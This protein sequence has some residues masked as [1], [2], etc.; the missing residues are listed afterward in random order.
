MAL[1]VRQ[2]QTELAEST[3]DHAPGA[4]TPKIGQRVMKLTLKISR[5]EMRSAAGVCAPPRTAHRYALRQGL[6]V[7]SAPPPRQRPTVAR[8]SLRCTPASATTTLSRSTPSPRSY[9]SNCP[10]G[11]AM[12]PSCC[13]ACACRGPPSPPEMDRALESSYNARRVAGPYRHS[14][15]GRRRGRWVQL[16]WD[17]LFHP[18]TRM[19]SRATWAD[20]M[21]AL[22]Q[23]PAR[24]ANRR[25]SRH[26][27]RAQFGHRRPPCRR[28]LPAPRPSHA[29]PFQ[30]PARALGRTRTSFHRQDLA[31][32]SGWDAAPHLRF[33][34][35]AGC[36]SPR[37]GLQ[38]RQRRA[39]RL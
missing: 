19:P 20:R 39:R 9:S 30:L 13:P 11:S 16:V 18:Q 4:N 22:R 31:A 7:R 37:L 3:N 2:L 10:H 27:P 23:F 34:A 17:C 5:G 1:P 6:A 29:W 15:H 35:P 28:G 24:P 36:L 26:P 8:L 25:C 32:A 21:P 12:S 14:P 33:R 38:A